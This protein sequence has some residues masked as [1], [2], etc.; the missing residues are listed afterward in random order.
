MP[1]PTREPE[2][3]KRAAFSARTRRSLLASM[4]L[5]AVALLPAVALTQEGPEAVK[6]E[7]AASA[8]PADHQAKAIMPKVI[9]TYGAEIDFMFWMIF[10]LTAVTFVIVEGLLVVFLIKYR[11]REGRTKA[12]HIH[13]SHKLE[14]AWTSATAAIL[15]VLGIW[16]N[17]A[18]VTVKQASARP[19][20]EES[21]LVRGYGFQFG[22]LFNYAGADGAWTDTKP[23]QQIGAA[24]GQQIGI[25]PPSADVTR[26]DLLVPSGVP[27][28]VE[29]HSIG[30]YTPPPE[31][32]QFD[33][34]K[35]YIHPVL[36]SFFSPNLRLKQDLVPYHPQ[37]VWFQVEEGE[38][39]VYE[40]SCAELCGEGHYTMRADLRVVT[41]AEFKSSDPIKGLGYDW[42]TANPGKFPEAEFY[43]DQHPSPE[44]EDEE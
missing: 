26:A 20:L 35:H 12:V 29:L 23:W 9:S 7:S 38:E 36:H 39:G 24:P 37:T 40:I 19:S 21:V 14:I 17:N 43:I 3:V 27:I 28:V 16:Q 25:Y 30:K 31:E 2:P 44:T 11:H 22:W 18:W 34:G 1:F 15:L 5:S 6:T 8:P 41:Q 42:T 33:I 10:W 13:G 4:I 32:E